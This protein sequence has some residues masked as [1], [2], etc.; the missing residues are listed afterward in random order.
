MSN[1]RISFEVD[2]RHVGG[3]LV[4]LEGRARNLNFE[5]VKEAGWGK[6]QPASPV[7]SPV[8]ARTKGVLK[9]M[10]EKIIREYPRGIE[11]MDLVAMIKLAGGKPQ[12]ISSGLRS[13]VKARLVR[14]KGTVYSPV[15]GTDG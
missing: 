7:G 9:A 15:G 5:I 4:A 3:C 6:N 12:G 14:R 11:Y 1:L 13:L 10:V 2:E 8:P